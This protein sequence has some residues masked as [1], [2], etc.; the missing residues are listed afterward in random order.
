[1]ARM[2]DRL[3]W[4][5]A[6]FLA[7]LWATPV[8]RAQSLGEVAEREKERRAREAQ[9]NRGG[10]HVISEEE[11]KKHGAKAGKRDSGAGETTS[12]EEITA[13]ASAGSSAS[14]TEDGDANKDY[15]R[16]RLDAARATVEQAE[17]RAQELEAAA[18][19]ARGRPD[20]TDY[21][22]ALQETEVRKARIAEYEAAKQNLEE[23]RRAYEALEQ[24]A[25]KAGGL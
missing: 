20:A 22:E 14:R 9:T 5:G 25:R 10:D 4:A 3:T 13:G 15:W 18:S 23:A 24:D 21:D 2:R 16:G 6:A 8:V 11:L 12:P 7:L 19:A 17:K 1:M